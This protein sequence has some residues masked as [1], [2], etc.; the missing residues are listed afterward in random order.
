M[1]AWRVGDA[2]RLGAIAHPELMRRCRTARIVE[3]YVEGK[4][5]K[6]KALAA[7]S[8]A[9]AL[10][11]FCEALRAI[12]PRDE[13]FDHFDRFVE[14]RRKNDLVIVVFESGVKRKSD[15][16]IIQSS[17]TEVVLKQVG[18]EWRFLW[19]IAAQIHIDLDWDPR[20]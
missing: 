1:A 19:S 5:D 17:S 16:K 18:N 20:T 8:D 4:D 11:L 9:N 6:K 14:V 7:G 10:A 2:K 13:R 3:F 15:Q 12:V